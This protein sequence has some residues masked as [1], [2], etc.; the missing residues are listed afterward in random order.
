MNMHKR[1]GTRSTCLIVAILATTIFGGAMTASAPV[2]ADSASAKHLTGD[3][4]RAKL[5]GNTLSG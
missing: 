2:R 1:L 5:A 3:E 4:I